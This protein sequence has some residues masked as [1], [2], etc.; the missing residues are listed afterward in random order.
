ME[1]I[2]ELRRTHYCSEISDSTVGQ[3]VVLMGWIQRRRDHGGVIF[4]DLRDRS[5]IV[6]LVLSSDID[7]VSFEK[8]QALRSECVIAVQGKVRLRPPGTENPNMITGKFEIA[9]EK[10]EVLNFAKNLPFYPNEAQD[11]DEA[12]RLRY[13]YLDL[14]RPECWNIFNMRHQAAKVIRDF[15]TK[16]SFLEIETPML[17][18]S[19]PEGARDY[20]VPSRI[21]PG[22]FFALPQSP[23][24]FKQ[25][26]MIAGFERYFQFARCFRDE[27][28]RADRQPEFT[29]LDLEMSFMSEDEIISLVEEMIS[30]LFARVLGVNL[31]IPFPRF[32]YEEALSSYGSDK[33]DL[34]LGMKIIDVS[35][36]AEK[37][38]CKVFFDAIKQGG[39]VKGI[40]VPGAATFSRKLLDE[41]GELVVSWGA[42]GLAWFAL[43]EGE[44]K[45]PL[46][47]LFTQ[48]ELH[49]LMKKLDGKPGDLLLFIADQKE[50]AESVLGQLRIELGKRLKLDDPQKFTFLWITD[51]PLFE[52]N[53]DERRFEAMH[54]P[55]TAPKDEDISLLKDNPQ[56]VRSKAYD[57]ILN[58]I[59][60]GGGSIR[61]HQR[62]LQEEIFQVIGLSKEEFEEKFGFLLEALDYGAP[63]H[64]GIAFGFDRLIML[65]LQR[66][67]IRDVI[68]F[69]KTQSATC[70]LTKAP[71]PVTAKQLKELHINVND[72]LVKQT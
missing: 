63:P 67:T 33:P 21:Y 64:G 54:H 72:V 11:V 56:A 4:L 8:G 44:I 9:V 53:E 65:M 1:R 28:L 70:L 58:G 18:R 42:K 66:E 31:S 37:T 26:L 46:A 43:G 14:R 20:L 29:Q 2:K 34:R 41:L 36:I 13:R 25:I 3:S 57:L 55:F 22:H 59:E 39:I 30:E 12:L 27:D 10:L 7:V 24:L 47:K 48:Q 6:Q 68:A 71:A 61:I 62:S 45:S 49:E 60:I 23:Q 50:K 15:L 69:P 51:F 32:S 38:S 17:T 40:C 35:P 16:R 19:T 5:S 52:Y